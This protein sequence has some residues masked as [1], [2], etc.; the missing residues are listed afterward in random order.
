MPVFPAF[1]RHVFHGKSE[2]ASSTSRSDGWGSGS[3][4]S[5]LAH[6][7]ARPVKGASKDPYLLSREYEELDDLGNTH[8]AS[9]EIK[10]TTTT[11]EGGCRGH[12]IPE[13][14]VEA[15]HNS[16]DTKALVFKSV[17]VESRPRVLEENPILPQ[18]A[19]LRN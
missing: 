10:G 5:G 13:Q 12:P 9:I 1:F 17:H 18:S 11:I 4:S 2:S 15:L 7:N 14:T 3:G 16:P 8:H 19:Y 6:R